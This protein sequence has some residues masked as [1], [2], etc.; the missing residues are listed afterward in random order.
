MMEFWPFR[1]VVA[2]EMEVPRGCR[3]V[4]VVYLRGLSGLFVLVVGFS[5]KLWRNLEGFAL[6]SD[7]WCGGEGLVWALA[8]VEN[9]KILMDFNSKW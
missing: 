9:D 4:I 7:V 3:V 2:G 8:V 6:K 1:G 5:T